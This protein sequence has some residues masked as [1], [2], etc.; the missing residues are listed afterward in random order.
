MNLKSTAAIACVMLGAS[1]SHVTAAPLAYVPNEKD[2]T[3]SVI[4]TTTDKVVNQ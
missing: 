4:D 2:G 1:I 3:V